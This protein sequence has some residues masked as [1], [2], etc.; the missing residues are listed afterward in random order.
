MI[1]A[2][3]TSVLLDV[4]TADREHLEGSRDALRDSIASGRLVACEVV[5]AEVV[6]F[7]PDSE[8]ARDALEQERFERF[9]QMRV[10]AGA[11][12]QGLYPPSE[13]TLVAYQT[14]VE[15]GEPEA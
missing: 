9:V 3:D 13:D 12:V 14:W 11:P 15:A 5:W 1:T 8:V 4:F 10:K 7:F 2:V 6:A